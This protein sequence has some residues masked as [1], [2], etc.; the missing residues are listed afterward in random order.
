M[1]PSLSSAPI[2]LPRDL[3]DGLR[4]RQAT[5]ADAEAL[6]TFNA[7]MHLEPDSNGFNHEIADWVREL[8]SGSHPTCG[9]ADFTLVEVI[10]TGEI[11]SSLNLISQTWSYGGI[12]FG[13]GRPE[14]VGTLP[15]YRKRGLVRLQM[16]VVH[17]WSTARGEP[18][19][20]ITGIPFYYRQFGYEMTVELGGG[21]RV[22][23]ADIPTLAE[24]TPEPFRIRPATEEDISFIVALDAQGTKRSLVTCL[25]DEAVW[26]Y[27]LQRS[28]LGVAYRQASVIES[29]SGERV[30]FFAHPVLLWGPSLALMVYE[31]APRVSWLAVTPSVLRHLWATGAAFA[32]DT[33]APY[34]SLYLR[35]GTTHPAYAVAPGPK[36]AL[37]QPYALFMRVPDLP[38][39]LH[40]IA[41]VLEQRLAASVAPGHTGDLR[42]SFYRSG[43]HLRL[44]QGRLTDSTPWQPTVDEGGDAAFPDLTFLHLL[45][46]HRSL[47]ELRHAFTDCWT[48][49]Q[50]VSILLDALFPKQPSFV[51][52]FS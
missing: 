1:S 31:L 7:K 12:P 37:D 46:G 27:E 29:A 15:A 11:V 42:L 50:E 23:P 30:G 5:L 28:R 47:D 44:E 33:S 32:A 22:Y 39:F 24:G 26:R 9:P 43:L 35:F 19:Q 8:M 6:A 2:T 48:A 18:V 51:W 52:P 41:P 45:F 36:I 16:E 40:H 13:V 20:A 21:R 10:E 25:R 34:N 49:S 14:L 38:A 3:G 4:L 17:E